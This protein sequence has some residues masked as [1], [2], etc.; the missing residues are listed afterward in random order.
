MGTT[1]DTPNVLAP[2][3]SRVF[4]VD[5]ERYAGRQGWVTWQTVVDVKAPDVATA[6]TRGESAAR[7]AHG[8]PQWPDKLRVSDCRLMGVARKVTSEP[9]GAG[10]TPPADASK[11]S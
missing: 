8:S 1:A 6:C 4:E 2:G 5:V 10:E 9:A 3:D 7:K 11:E